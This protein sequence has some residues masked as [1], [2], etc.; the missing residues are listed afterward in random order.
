MPQNWKR[1][2]RRKTPTKADQE[3]RSSKQDAKSTLSTTTE[4]DD[5]NSVS[6]QE[7]DVQSKCSRRAIVNLQK[8]LDNVTAEINHEQEEKPSKVEHETKVSDVTDQ[9]AAVSREQ[10]GENESRQSDDSKSND[11]VKDSPVL[12]E[13]GGQSSSNSEEIASDPPKLEKEEP[14]SQTNT[15]PSMTFDSTGGDGAPHV[16]L[17]QLPS[18]I[19]EQDDLEDSPSL[20]IDEHG[21]T[22]PT[23]GME[24]VEPPSNG[25][26]VNSSIK[27]SPKP[28]TPDLQ[29]PA[30][31]QEVSD[32]LSQQLEES[33]RESGL[34]TPEVAIKEEMPGD[35]STPVPAQPPPVIAS[36]SQSTSSVSKVSSQMI[37]LSQAM[38]FLCSGNS[39]KGQ[40]LSALEAIKSLA[41]LN[42][43]KQLARGQSP[44]NPVKCETFQNPFT[45]GNGPQTSNPALQMPP[46]P[47][48][49]SGK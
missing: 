10:K 30:H 21:A 15:P 29:L 16:S 11:K 45:Q 14:Y 12:E 8:I 27:M 44:I 19:L 47:L 13:S 2:P 4:T 24:P 31:L 35:P 36:S 17:R 48:S 40:E 42:Q 1:S 26:T 38:G 23:A 9:S 43:P 6:S 37:P 28:S 22:P 5:T 41:K 33:R 46:Q 7:E 25:P 34:N 20:I 3:K 18:S 39:D 49:P 32:Q